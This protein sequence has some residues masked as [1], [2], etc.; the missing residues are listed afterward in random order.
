MVYQPST[1][2]DA[3]AA[4]KP[5]YSWEA[6]MAMGD[7]RYE[8]ELQRRVA[9][10]NPCAVNTLVYTS[11]TTGAP[12][13]VMLTHDNMIWPVRVLR[14]IGEDMMT[15]NERIVSYLPLSHSAAQMTDIYQA[16]MI[17]ATVYFADETALQGTLLET[18]KEARP[19][20]FFS[21]PRIY[22]KME[23]SFK[24]AAA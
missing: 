19:T 22:E 12:K 15:N 16:I 18:L 6:F 21:V 23:E 24:A 5:I 7:L 1:E 9:G 3:I 8:E 13:G 4:G 20:V 11:G 17:R 14:D 2:L 10:Q